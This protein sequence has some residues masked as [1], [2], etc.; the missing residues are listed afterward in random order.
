M[1]LIRLD[2]TS[3]KLIKFDQIWSK[4]WFLINFDQFW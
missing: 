1:A 3:S 2:Q 4:I